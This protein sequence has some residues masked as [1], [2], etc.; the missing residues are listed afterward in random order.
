M[1]D[2]RLIIAGSLSVFVGLLFLLFGNSDGLIAIG[3]LFIVVGAAL[4][5]YKILSV[6]GEQGTRGR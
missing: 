5:I 2:W 4:V 1:S 3:L 6:S